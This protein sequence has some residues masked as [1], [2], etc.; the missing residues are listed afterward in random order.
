MFKK[1]KKEFP[2]YFY[3]C[4]VDTYFVLNVFLHS[5]LQGDIIPK[6]KKILRFR[7]VK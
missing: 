2:F 6:L 7:E 5:G 3:S 4:L 1:K